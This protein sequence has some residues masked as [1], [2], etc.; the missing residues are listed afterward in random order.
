M[1]WNWSAWVA[2]TLLAGAGFTAL[3]AWLWRRRRRARTEHQ[4]TADDQIAAL[5]TAFES[6]EVQLA[7]ADGPTESVGSGGEVPAAAA[8]PAAQQED[9]LQPEMMAAITAAAT[10]FLGKSDRPGSAGKIQPAQQTVSPWSQQGRMMVETS[11]NLHAGTR[12]RP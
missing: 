3:Y 5:A 11:H 4:W 2:V 7:G 6:L 8:S 1:K 10:A 12:R 9:P